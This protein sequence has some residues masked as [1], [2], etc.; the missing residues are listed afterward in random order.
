MV[1]ITS[2]LHLNHTNIIKYNDRPFADVNAM[3]NI[4]ISNINNTVKP[5]DELYILGD[6]CFGDR[7]RANTFLNQIRCKNI[8]L[9][10]GNHDS[11]LK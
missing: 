4:L 3:N 1:Y 7:L 9:I 6:F 11:F 2:D 5:T 8:Y 10:K